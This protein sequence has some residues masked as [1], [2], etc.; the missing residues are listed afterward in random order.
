MLVP[1]LSEMGTDLAGVLSDSQ[2]GQQLRAEF[3][4]AALMASLEEGQGGATAGGM[5]PA[6]VTLMKLLG[7]LERVAK[8][9]VAYGSPARVAEAQAAH[10]T[11]TAE[12]TQ[13][14]T[15]HAA[16]P[17]NQAL[18][19]ALARALRLLLTQLKLLKLDAANTKL[20]ML[21]S[22]LNAGRGGVA[23][24]QNKFAAAYLSPPT[25]PATA[26][27]P[28]AAAVASPPAAAPDTADGGGGSAGAAAASGPAGQGLTNGAD[29]AAQAPEAQLT[30]SQL[31]RAL[32]RTAAWL[33][34]TLQTSS[35]VQ[36]YLDTAGLSAERLA[37]AGA[38]AAAAAAA[39]GS[40]APVAMQTGERPAGG[41]SLAATSATGAALAPALRGAFPVLL[42]SW[43]G[44]VRLG[45]VNLV[46]GE[47]PA[48]AP[49]LV[50]ETL[51]WERERLHKA[52]T[53]FQRCVVLTSA[54]LLIQ[55]SRARAGRPWTGEQKAAARRRM[56]VLLADPGIRMP[57]L[58]TALAGLAGVDVTAE[59][60][61]QQQTLCLTVC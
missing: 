31:T 19:T 57:E 10:A 18:S 25:A 48:A 43:R 4:P 38:A 16:S 60:E 11:M 47:K 21:S 35:L 9:L 22:S 55:Q 8:L 51:L 20:A 45:L 61:Q 36:Q 42:S 3:A 32:P 6:V 14:L 49:L 50:P 17:Q 30:P 12:L 37:T 52:Q 15:Q 41:G 58:V 5:P 29:S 59:G 28:P 46:S 2:A 53:S 7:V 1:L 56:T 24:L 54:L 27:G 33:R 13:L 23:Y 26:T 44:T 39:A 34:D 40:A